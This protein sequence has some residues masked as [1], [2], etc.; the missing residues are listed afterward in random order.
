MKTIIHLASAVLSVFAVLATALAPQESSAATYY[1]DN[2]SS[3]PG[4]GTAGGTWAAPTP[5]PIPGWTTDA[6]GSSIPG[7]ISTTTSDPINFGNG[8]TGLGAGTVTLSGT[9]SSSNI[10]F[11]SGSGAIVLSGGTSLTL[12][13][14]AVITVNNSSDTIATPLAGAATGLIKA[15]SGRLILSGANAVA[16]AVTVNSGELQ[17]NGGSFS[18]GAKALNVA[19]S[20]GQVAVVSIVNGSLTN[21]TSDSIGTGTNAVAVLKLSGGNFVKTAGNLNLGSSNI[22]KTNYAAFLMSSGYCSVG[23]EFALAYGTAGYVNSAY[24]NLSGGMM[25][26]SNYCTVGREGLG[27]LD[28][29]GGTFFRPTTAAQK[30]YMT[31]SAGS[32]AQLT[33]RGTGTLDIEDNNGLPFG[34]NNVTANT[35]MVNLM[36]GGTLISRVGISWG[37]TGGAVGHINFNGGT[38]KA[39]GSSAT[40][41]T[42]LWSAC[43]FYSGGATIDSQGNSIT[44]AQPFLV[45]TGNGVTSIIGGTGS[46][47]LAPPV[48]S[49]TGDGTGATAI[50]QVDSSGNVTNILIT[51]PGVNYTTAA[52]A[53]IGGGGTA[54]GWTAAVGANAATGGLTK[55]GSGTLTLSGASTYQGATRIGAGVLAIAA[56]NYPASSALTLSNNATLNLDVT[57]GAST[58]ASPSLTLGTN[59]TLNLSYGALAGNPFQP[60]I[61]DAT[62]NAGTVLTAN[63]TNIVINLSGLGFTAGQVPI[64]KYSGS[65]GGKGFAA[66]KLGNLPSGVPATSQLVN[67]TANKSIDLSIPLVNTLTWNGTNSDWDINTTFN[68]KDSLSSPSVY[69]QYGTTNIYGDVV[70]FDD[71]LSNPSQTSINLTTTLRPTVVNLSAGNAAYAFGGSGKL[72]GGSF[73]NVSGG[74]TVTISTANDYTGGS[75]LS[76]GTVLVGNDAALGAGTVTLAGAILAS[77]SA[78]PRTL[79]NAVSIIADTTL[80]TGPANGALTL[81]GPVDLGGIAHGLTL[82]NNVAL[83]GPLSNGGISKSG[84][85]TLTLDN[86]GTVLS[87]TIWINAGKVTLNNGTFTGPFNVAPIINQTAIIEIGNANITNTA[88]NNI[89]TAPNNVGVVKQSG[90]SFVESGVM[91]FGASS[92]SAAYLM[93]GGY[94]YFGGDTR[95]DYLGAVGLISQSGGTMVSANYFSLARDGGLGVYDLSGG[96]HYR[97]ATSVNRFYM[98]RTEGSTAQVNIRGTGTMDIE[99]SLGLSFANDYTNT[100]YGCVNIL[101]GGT[102]ISR[103]GLYFGNTGAATVGYVNFNGGTLR[104][105]GSK[106]NY[107]SGWTGGYIYGGGATIDSQDNTIGIGQTLLTPTGSGVTSITGFSG[108]GYLSPPV[109]SI[110]GDGTGATAVAQI[111]A[112]GNVTGILVTCPGVNYTYASVTLN[113]GGGSGSG[114]TAN[115]GANATTGGLTK[116]GSGTLT[117]SGTNT[118][119][120]LTA[121]GN[122]TLVLGKAHAAPGNITVADGATLGCWSDT[123]GTSVRL[124]SA[125]LGVGTGAGLLARFTGNTGNPATPA[126]YITNLTL[127]GSTPVSVLCSGIQAGTIP[128][129]QYSTLGGAGSITT[130]TLPQGVVGAITNNTAT[131]TIEL[132][133][134]S[135]APLVW[136]GAN[137]TSWDINVTTNWLIGAAPKTFLDGSGVLFDDTAVNPSV[138]VTQVVSPGSIVF[139]NN[140]LAYTVTTSGSGALGGA[141]GLVKAGTNSLILSGANTYLGPTLISAGTLEVGIGGTAGSLPTGGSIQID[142]GATLVHNRSDTAGFGSQNI[143][144]SGTLNKI[145]S[146]DGPGLTG[147]NTFSG[148]INIQTATLGLVGSESENGQPSVY[149][150]PGARLAIGSGFNSG[151]ATIGNLTGGGDVNASYTSGA[152]TRGLQVNQTT[153]G[154]FAGVIADGTSSRLVALTKTG[155]AALTLSGTSTYTGPTAVSNGTLIVN[156]AISGSAVAVEAGAALG[157]SGTLAVSVSF[158]AGSVAT[159]NVGSPLTV[160]TLDMAGNGAMHVATASPIGAGEYPLISYTTLTGSGQFTTLHIGGAGLAPGTTASVVFTNSA[161][162]LSV[163]GGSPAATNIT[164]TVNAGQL[165]LDWPAG[166]G[167]MLQSNSVS[168]VSPNSWFNVTGATPPFTNTVNPA[169]PPV[170]Y[171]LKY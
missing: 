110:P 46:G 121:V 127:N 62:I 3:T 156:G 147:T 132:V 36:T 142:A 113:G 49:I 26:C 99:D 112:S 171:R 89:A 17:L 98:T 48:V 137:G 71:T 85:G 27:T 145:G 32:F 95:L 41:W 56:G 120:G 86:A 116:L 123:P 40:F 94:A 75:T 9:L 103:A 65:I 80:G 148:Q 105:S 118:Y 37:N 152:G 55:L 162:A 141:T 77:D 102:L 42:S 16:G 60:A 97:P 13:A 12:P 155:P 146:S 160:G 51:N 66:F 72:S 23:G 64:I 128:L 11:A 138:M 134:T 18:L 136:S 96:T 2:D 38:L 68:W 63:G 109:V 131:K 67:N 24:A 164:Y 14:T 143:S 158:A 111:D 159:N 117:L 47:Y 144:G 161:V 22:G 5:G 140:A 43:Y 163:V 33:I 59:T 151:Y 39:N 29:S 168:L 124:P 79:A 125:T 45:P 58:L 93:S 69:K 31:R 88:Q 83:T 139:S 106:A 150:A 78:A 53:L 74:A 153:D 108:S 101:T 126:G 4:F 122:G 7:S 44:I 114:G 87:D 35:G 100:A 169:N 57:G 149:V 61:S 135:I 6:T 92:S 167:W 54:S 166:Q 104:A 70:T 84:A 30:F 50:A 91:A 154:T 82:E 130:G 119:G 8:A 129:I 157:G 10:T 115:L 73:L 81:A 21:S 52:V 133:I 165:V 25:A 20:T 170:F 90:G 15:G 76:A 28:I 1:Y 107:W 34:N 19:A